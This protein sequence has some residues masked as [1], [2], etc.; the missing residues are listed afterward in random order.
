MLNVAPNSGGVGP[1]IWMSGGGPA[2]DSSGNIYLLT[3]NGVFETTL[4]ANGFP[5][6]QDYGNSFLKISTAG[7]TLRVADYFTMYNEAAES[8]ADQDLGSGGAMLLPDLADGGGTVRH[9]AVGAGQGRQDL[10]RESRLDGQ[11]RFH[12]AIRRSGSR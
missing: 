9:L 4:D 10:H 12:R 2:A 8:A 11:I 6:A 7:G 3:A 1:A 5:S